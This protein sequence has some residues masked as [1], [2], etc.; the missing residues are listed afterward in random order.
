MKAGKAIGVGSYGC[1]FKPNLPCKD[2]ELTYSGISKLMMKNEAK[3]EYEIVD[4]IMSIIESIDDNPNYFIPNSKEKFVLCDLGNYTKNDLDNSKIC[5]NFTGKKLRSDNHLMQLI[6]NNKDKIAI[7]QQSDGGIDLNNTIINFNP[8]FSDFTNI[9]NLLIRLIENGI[10]PM[11]RKGLLHLDIKTL[12]MVYNEKLNNIRLIDWGFALNI[13]ELNIETIRNN[14][15]SQVMMF[16]VP[17]G[18]ILFND[19]TLYKIDKLIQIN[20]DSENTHTSRKIANQKY[21]NDKLFIPYREK[22][23]HWSIINKYI[24]YVYQD[25]PSNVIWNNYILS[26]INNFTVYKNNSVFF[27][28]EKYFNTVYKKNVD[29]YGVLLT[30]LDLL[31]IEKLNIEEEMNVIDFAKKYIFGT[32][33]AIKPYDIN[34]L[35][36]DMSKLFNTNINYSL[37]TSSSPVSSSPKARASLKASSKSKKSKK[38]KRK[39]DSARKAVSRRRSSSIRRREKISER[40]FSI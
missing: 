23:K 26:I 16:N 27:D 2:R 19:D 3:K 10:V 9:N 5:S 22:S 34:I 6:D 7:L 40:P 4:R 15:I 18:N 29:I 17:I 39:A 11:N 31:L 35:T 14:L 32:E 25:I 20:I 21:I 38:T 36:K 33:Y 1:V 8:Y 24:S 30:Y 37:G 12:N 28:Y 13:N